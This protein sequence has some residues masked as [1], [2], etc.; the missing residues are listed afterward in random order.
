MKPLYKVIFDSNCQKLK[1]NSLIIRL[2]RLS[3]NR[4]SEDHDTHSLESMTL[5]GVLFYRKTTPPASLSDIGFVAS[6]NP[7]AS[8][9]GTCSS[10]HS[11]YDV[12]WC[13][14]NYSNRMKPLYK[15]IF[16]SNCQMLKKKSLIIIIADKKR[17]IGRVFFFSFL[18]V[19]VSTKPQHK[20]YIQKSYCLVWKIREFLAQGVFY[21]LAYNYSFKGMDTSIHKHIARKKK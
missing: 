7:L 4:H 1:K 3:G 11:Y 19:N 6:S 5:E 15:V 14:D 2:T 13:C 20:G 17:G 21:Y 10:F 16:D 12:W 18:F 9:T 8:Y